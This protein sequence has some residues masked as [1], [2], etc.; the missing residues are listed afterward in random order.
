MFSVNL[1]AE[2]CLVLACSHIN[3]NQ[4][5]LDF[6]IKEEPSVNN[7][8]AIGALN[9]LSSNAALLSRY[10]R[11]LIPISSCQ[12]RDL[13]LWLVRIISSN[14]ATL[15]TSIV[16]RR[17][18]NLWFKAK[19]YLFK[20]KKKLEIA[21]LQKRNNNAH[22]LCMKHFI[23]WSELNLFSFRWQVPLEIIERAVLMFEH[24]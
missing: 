19:N 23:L 5:H 21:I 4:S 9:I 15:N 8:Q 20:K 3:L 17:T 13:M 10:H 11:Y 14:G 6:S 22:W 16:K 1:S 18:L 12:R 24:C 2:Y 7:T